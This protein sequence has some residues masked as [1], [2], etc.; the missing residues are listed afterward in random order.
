MIKKAAVTKVYQINLYCD[1]CGKR[2]EREDF[3]LT[4]M[5]PQF[6]YKCIC[7]HTE[8]STTVYPYQQIFFDEETAEEIEE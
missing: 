6:L 8:T 5:P 7:G 4:S 3:A 2:M 1:K